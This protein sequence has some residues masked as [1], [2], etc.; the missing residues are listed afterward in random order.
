MIYIEREIH[1]KAGKRNHSFTTNTNE[2]FCTVHLL[3]PYINSFNE[4]I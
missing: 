3:V 4:T 1:T 2:Q